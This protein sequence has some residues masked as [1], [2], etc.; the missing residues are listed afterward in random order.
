M[1]NGEKTEPLS[2]LFL[3]GRLSWLAGTGEGTI[4]FAVFP[5]SDIVQ[6]SALEA[7]RLK[8]P[9][10]P[11]L[12]AHMS[13]AGGLHL[14]IE[15]GQ[16]VGCTALQIFTKNNNQWRGKA[17]GE[18]EAEQFRQA[19][20]D[21]GIGPI[22]AHNAYLINLASPDA[23]TH[24][25]S[26]TAMLDELRR[27]ERLGL[28]G[29]VIHPGSHMGKGEN[30]GLKR[31]ASSLDALHARTP[32]YRV[33]ILL[34]ITAGQGNHLGYR[35]EHLGE[36]L[37]RVKQPERLGI[38]FDTC[39][40]FAAGYDIGTIKGYR[41]TMRRFDSTL[42]LDRLRVFHLNDSKS[43]FRSRVDRHEHIGQGTL[44]L[45][46]FRFI[47]NDRRFASVPKVIETPKQPDLE[48]DRMNLGVLRGLVKK[49]KTERSL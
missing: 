47:L 24:R 7:K 11:F 31:I 13:I 32:E 29:L 1:A 42:G 36:I 18:D 35:F 44:G 27:A 21:S 40:A 48:E 33:T 25:K 46:A 2:P 30:W 23:E 22:I 15:R 3:W 26:M 34:E 10:V 43:A 17:L 5:Y 49:G 9:A 6:P 14:A 45:D 39:H 12:G 8:K 20:A 37:T 41:A 38:C 28:S 19:W 16:S 4:A